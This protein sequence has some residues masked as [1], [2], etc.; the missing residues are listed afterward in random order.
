MIEMVV[1]NKSLYWQFFFYLLKL[2]CKVCSDDVVI[3]FI[4]GE[5]TNE[6]GVVVVVISLFDERFL[7]FV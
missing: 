6:V 5:R 4:E 1:Y 3:V 2:T 7:I